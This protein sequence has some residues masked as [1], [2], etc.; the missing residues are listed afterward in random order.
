MV[1]QTF[2]RGEQLEFHPKIVNM[3][4]WDVHKF[5]I[6][7]LEWYTNPRKSLLFDILKTLN[8]NKTKLYYF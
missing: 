6:L 8:K 3:C 1:Y 4:E 5:I 7:V 2:L